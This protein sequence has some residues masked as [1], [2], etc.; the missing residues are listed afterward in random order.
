M[1]GSDLVVASSCFRNSHESAI[2]FLFGK[3]SLVP[4]ILGPRFLQLELE[5]VV[6]LT[7]AI[8]SKGHFPRR[9]F[10]QKSAKLPLQHNDSDLRINYHFVPFLPEVLF[11]LTK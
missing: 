9:L 7:G 5:L 8:C 10:T 1:E 6:P 3:A 11:Q 2:L 4:K